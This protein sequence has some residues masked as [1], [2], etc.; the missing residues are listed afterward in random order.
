MRKIILGILFFCTGISFII[1]GYLL[2]NFITV[3]ETL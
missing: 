2:Y 3:L 1:L